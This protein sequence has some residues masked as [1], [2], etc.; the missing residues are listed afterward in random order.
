MYKFLFHFLVFYL[1]DMLY[2]DRDE[3]FF[4]FD[5]LSLPKVIFYFGWD[6][7]TGHIGPQDILFFLCLYKLNTWKWL[8]TSPSPSDQIFPILGIDKTKLFCFKPWP[9]LVWELF[10]PSKDFNTDLAIWYPLA[11]DIFPFDISSLFLT[12]LC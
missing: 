10:D 9:V 11:K 7:I 8:P 2:G 4:S 6:I 3:F 5:C 12:F 1:F